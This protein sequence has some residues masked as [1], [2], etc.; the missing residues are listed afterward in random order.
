MTIG[1]TDTFS[2]DKY[3]QYLRW[4]QRTAPEA[5]YRK[6]S[7]VLANADAVELLDGLVLTGGGDIHPK[8]YEREDALARVRGVEE[9]RDGFE[10]ELIDRALDRDLPILGVC[11]G[12]QTMNVALGGSLII[13][14]PTD[15]YKEHRNA[16]ASALM[17]PLGIVPHSM[18]H[19]LAGGLDASVNSFHHQAV[20]RLGRGLIRTAISTDGVVEAAEWALKDDMPF[21]L[22]V[23][24]HP[25][26]MLEDPLSERIAQIFVREAHQY[27]HDHQHHT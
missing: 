20:D 18:L 21:L 25:E 4:L 23:Q 8:F 3:E 13:D 11:R 12:M 14:L 6:L 19:L 17:H 2:E 10:F 24:W 7:H 15:G 27:H 22:L 26:R 9:L 1:V 16:D 5:E